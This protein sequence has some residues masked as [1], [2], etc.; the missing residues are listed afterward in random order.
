MNKKQKQFTIKVLLAIIGI[1]F[2]GI[3]I[4]FNAAALLG[5]DPISVVYDGVRQTIGFSSEQFG[6]VSSMV[7]ITLMII[8][9]LCNKRY[10]NI[11]TFIYIVSLATSISLGNRLF[12]ILQLDSNIVIRSISAILGCFLL[13][14]GIAV[15]IV[16]DIGLDP[17]TGF[18]MMLS[19]RLKRPF[20]KVKIVF[21]IVT[22]IIGVL[23]GGQIGIITVF[24]ALAAGP[25]IQ[26]FA[27]VLR[28]RFVSENIETAYTK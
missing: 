9:F 15:Y 8:V 25:S 14:I 1:G 27:D 10:I 22:L 26:Y 19:D 12:Y 5:N 3:G 2:A 18:V 20:N 11:G 4:A 13:F 6:V 23:L 24:T 7:N 16:V 21:D 28:K 17:W